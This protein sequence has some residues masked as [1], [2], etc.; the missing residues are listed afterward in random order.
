MMSP[1]NAAIAARDLRV[2]QPAAEV[3]RDNLALGV[4]GCG[5]LPEPDPRGIGLGI[6]IEMAEQPSSPSDRQHEHARSHRVEGA[7]MAD[8]TG[9]RDTPKPGHDIVRRHPAGLSTIASP[10][11]GSPL[12]TPAHHARSPGRPGD[13]PAI[14]PGSPDHADQAGEDEAVKARPRLP[15]YPNANTARPD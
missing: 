3:G 4:V 15:R 7:G 10:S 14:A 2:A 9:V 11:V 13:Q 6:E 12:A 8:S 1:T 5:R